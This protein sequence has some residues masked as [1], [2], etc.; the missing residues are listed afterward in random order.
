MQPHTTEVS[1]TIR[2]TS[3]K[4]SHYIGYAYIKMR[5]SA[6]Q[7]RLGKPVAQPGSARMGEVCAAQR[8]SLGCD[9]NQVLGM[10]RVGPNL[11]KREG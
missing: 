10:F 4:M 3:Y 11:Q 9:S 8:F 6:S 5:L 7:Q 2:N 1:S